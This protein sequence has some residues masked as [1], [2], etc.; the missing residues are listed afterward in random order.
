MEQEGKS[1]DNENLSL[2]KRVFFKSNMHV[3]KNKYCL[4]VGKIFLFQE[5]KEL[6]IDHSQYFFHHPI[7]NHNSNHLKVFR[8][9]I[10]DRK[11]SLCTH[12]IFK[13]IE[14]IFH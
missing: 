3:L 2:K 4:L 7:N 11:S 9:V 12:H 10:N 1:S 5:I 6:S 8:L 14:I 13:P